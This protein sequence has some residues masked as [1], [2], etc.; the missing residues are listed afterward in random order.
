ML[1]PHSYAPQKNFSI[2]YLKMATFGASRTL[3]FTVHLPVL[4]A[5]TGAVGLA[6]SCCVHAEIKKLT[7]EA[8]GGGG[9][10]P[11]PPLGYATVTVNVLNQSVATGSLFVQ[12]IGLRVC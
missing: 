8:F 6:T 10:P 7:D 4:E 2:F 12:Q 3:F 5:K 11:S 9:R 1:P